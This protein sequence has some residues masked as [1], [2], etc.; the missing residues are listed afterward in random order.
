MLVHTNVKMAL[1]SLR[2]SKMHS[3]LTMFGIIVGVSSVVT[4]VSLGEGFKQQIRRQVE[5]TGTD[6]ISIRPGRFVTRNDKGEVTGINLLNSLGGS[7][8]S[9]R[10]I[11]IITK[12]PDIKTVVPFSIVTGLPS[13]EGNEYTKGTIL[14]TTEA[15]P[16][17]LNQKI[18]H[19]YFF[20]KESAERNV[21]VIGRAV[22][23]ELFKEEA[24]VGKSLTIRGENFIVTGIFEEFPSI[25]INAGRDFNTTVFIPYLAAKRISGGNLPMFEVL[26]KPTT[27]DQVHAVADALHARLKADRSGQEDFTILKSEENVVLA[28]NVLELATTMI[29][30]IAA[31]SLL[32]GGIGIMNIMFAL[33]TERTREIGIRKAIGANNQQILSQFLIEAVTLSAVGGVIGIML[34]LLANAAFRIWTNLEPVINIPIMCIALGVSI[35]VGVLSGVIPAYR[36]ARKDPI[37]ALR[38]H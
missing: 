30:G 8:I 31:I 37:E 21:A 6:T 35:V 10:E 11:D 4:M 17:I 26:V 12:T 29:S 25:N 1:T 22:A 5:Q 15:A 3:F 13:I 23:D 36:A 33:V 28:D 20:E 34:S 24:P 7:V 18:Q 32:V 19:G 16:L 14:A 9:E 2:Q 38:Y 27:P